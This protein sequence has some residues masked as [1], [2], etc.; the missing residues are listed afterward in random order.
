MI[1]GPGSKRDP[2]TQE[3]RKELKKDG[4]PVG[5]ETSNPMYGCREIRTRESG[6]SGKRDGVPFRARARAIRVSLFVQRER[7]LFVV[8]LDQRTRCRFRLIF[9]YLGACISTVCR[10]AVKY[11]AVE[12]CWQRIGMYI[13]GNA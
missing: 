7:R 8:P 1:E 9:S 6:G 5:A 12:F 13:V 2:R 11:H 4:N 10:N 3:N